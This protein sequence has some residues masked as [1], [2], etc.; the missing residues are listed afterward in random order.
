MTAAPEVPALLTLV[1][2]A[3]EYREA[4]RAL[5]PLRDAYCDTTSSEARVSS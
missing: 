1:G 2:A 3:M 4:E 5:T